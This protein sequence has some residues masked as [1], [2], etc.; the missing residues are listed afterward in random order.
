[1]K[2]ALVFLTVFALVL[3]AALGTFYITQN[4]TAQAATG[5]STVLPS[6]P[7]AQRQFYPTIV[8]MGEEGK[9]T[10]RWLG[11]FVAKVGDTVTLQVKNADIECTE[12]PHGFALPAYGISV[13]E[14]PPGT[15]K[16]FTFTATKAGI[17]DFKCAN[18]KCELDHDQQLGQLIVL[19]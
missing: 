6:E 16:T 17:F 19:P 8:M 1:M 9:E 4:K 10:H 12:N 11:S 15:D 18:E 7:P 2:N 13:Q 3:G 5:G 14:I